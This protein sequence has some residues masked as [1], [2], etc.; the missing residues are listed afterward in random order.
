MKKITYIIIAFVALALLVILAM[1][2]MKKP[3]GPSSLEIVTHSDT[4]TG[5]T[6]S[7][8]IGWNRFGNIPAGFM[9]T[10]PEEKSVLIISHSQ[11]SN[12]VA[13]Y[14]STEELDQE[15]NNLLNPFENNQNY[16]LISNTSTEI[17]NV[18]AKD[19]TFSYQDKDGLYKVRLLVIGKYKGRFHY[20]S[21]YSNEAFEKD[22][23]DFNK[24]I[25]SIKF[26]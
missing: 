15:V 11:V 3:T 21:L 25:K 2:F 17:N 14:T 6:F 16:Q 22:M 10:S 23:P 1:F 5:I 24:I 12:V 18:E 4:E 7:Y 20:F 9:L 8:P 19:A 26:K 13:T